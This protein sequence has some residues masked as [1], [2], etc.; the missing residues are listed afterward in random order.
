MLIEKNVYIGEDVGA[1]MTLIYI[2][3]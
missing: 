2:N 3:M 1:I